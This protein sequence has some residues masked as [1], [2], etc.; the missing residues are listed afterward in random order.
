MGELQV[1]IRQGN[2]KVKE[3]VTYFNFYQVLL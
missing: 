3:E 1:N 2:F